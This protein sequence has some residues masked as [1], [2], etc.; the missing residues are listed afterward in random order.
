MKSLFISFVIL[1]LSV[2]MSAQEP[3]PIQ[4]DTIN[5]SCTTSK[6]IQLKKRLKRKTKTARIYLFKNSRIKKELAFKTKASRSKL[7]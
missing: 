6:D 3:Q 5:V 1:F 7:S 2:D 4:L